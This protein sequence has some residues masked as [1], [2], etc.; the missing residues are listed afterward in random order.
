MTNILKMLLIVEAFF[1]IIICKLMIK[2]YNSDLKKYQKREKG[3][4]IIF[5]LIK[6]VL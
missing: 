2:F 5:S 4:K 1:S 3:F 6:R